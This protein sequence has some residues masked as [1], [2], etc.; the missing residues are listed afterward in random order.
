MMVSMPDL[1]DLKLPADFFVCPDF[2]SHFSKLRF[3]DVSGALTK[4]VLTLPPTVECL[5]INDTRAGWD[6]ASSL[7]LESKT[8]HFPNLREFEYKAT[9]RLSPF[10]LL[11]LIL[12]PEGGPRSLESVKLEWHTFFDLDEF[13]DFC[14]RDYFSQA[15]SRL[16]IFKI[17]SATSLDDS[18]ISLLEVAPNLEVFDA[19]G[20]SITGVTVKALVEGNKKLHTLR[21]VECIKISADAVEFARNAGINVIMRQESSQ[22]SG[23]RVRY[24]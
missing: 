16:R 6:H 23:K 13:K 21:L 10:K 11:D 19:T 20:C 17:T 7:E 22:R 9:G 1:E 24:L 14:R 5:K 18:L 2:Y 3:V 8:P 12:A 4:Q 15:W